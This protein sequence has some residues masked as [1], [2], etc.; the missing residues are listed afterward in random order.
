MTTQMRCRS[1]NARK[2]CTF[3]PLARC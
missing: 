3:S 2:F 1:K